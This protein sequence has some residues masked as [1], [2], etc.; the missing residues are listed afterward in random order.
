MAERGEPSNPE[1]VRPGGSSEKNVRLEGSSENLTNP[2]PIE[3]APGPQIGKDDKE[4][5]T[6]TAIPLI[7]NLPR[8]RV[9]PRVPEPYKG[10][11]DKRSVRQWIT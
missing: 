7:A 3:S 5:D 11:S 8:Y 6:G 10:T 1:T 4:S 9:Q 2:L